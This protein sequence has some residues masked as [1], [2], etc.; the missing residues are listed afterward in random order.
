M[1]FKRS[2]EGIIVPSANFVEFFGGCRKLEE[3]LVE[4]ILQKVFRVVRVV[5]LLR[6]AR[7][8][9]GLRSRLRC[10]GVFLDDV[11]DFVWNNA[12]E[13][14]FD[15]VL[16]GDSNVK[17]SYEDIDSEIVVVT[18]E[19]AEVDSIELDP[20]GTQTITAGE[21]IDFNA[22]VYDEYGN[23]ITEDDVQFEWENTDE[24]GMFDETQAG[25]YEIT[26]TYEE[27]T[28]DTVTVTVEETEDQ[29]GGLSN[30]CGLWWILIIITLL[31]LGITI[32]TR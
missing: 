31:I 23:L 24:T 27:V 9:G 16:V 17:A 22:S 4:D 20:S 14:L 7:C 29:D 15:S 18:V 3:F 19:H 32:E 1:T 11:T 10:L 5:R 26:A 13:G 21:T 28:S 30:L 8:L 25:D 2:D 6:S 12:S